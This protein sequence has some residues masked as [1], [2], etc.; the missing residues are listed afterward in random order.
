MV[1]AAQTNPPQGGGGDDTNDG[2]PADDPPTDGAERGS[3]GDGHLDA[4]PLISLFGGIRPMAAKLGV[5]VSTVQGWRERNAI[6]T[7]RLTSI[8]DAAAKNDITILPEH[9]VLQMGPPTPPDSAPG[10]RT[11]GAAKPRRTS[12]EQVARTPGNGWLAPGLAGAAV[13]I[14]VIALLATLLDGGSGPSSDSTGATQVAG[15][16]A[17]R[18]DD[19]A[20][21]A[22]SVAARVSVL[23]TLAE[24][25]AALD[26][27][28]TALAQRVDADVIG[29]VATLQSQLDDL[30]ALAREGGPDAD[31][32][33]ARMDDLAAGLDEMQGSLDDLAAIPAIPSAQADASGEI[34]ALTT[35][36]DGLA[37]ALAAVQGSTWAGDA[38]LAA[39]LA[40]RVDQ[41]E[42]VL[43]A[44]PAGI[45]SVGDGAIGATQMFATVFAT[46]RL[47]Q[48]LTDGGP[49][50]AVLAQ[51]AQGVGDDGELA[52]LVAAVDDAVGSDAVAT[53]PAL[54]RDF[55]AMAPGL[56]RA[57]SRGTTAVPE[58]ADWLAR[59]QA[60]LAQVVTVE[61]AEV[62][63]TPAEA[64]TGDT[65]AQAGALV[66]TGDLAAAAAAISGMADGTGAAAAWVTRAE[67]RVAVETALE[68]LEAAVFA[69]LADPQAADP[70]AADPQAADPQAVD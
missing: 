49:L 61:R 47:R 38:G 36:V 9:V 5:P 45:A 44:A 18:V 26:E 42:A 62:D 56:A 2:R 6:P 39:G 35:R 30:A 17:G 58:D 52:G 28:I 27:Q 4:H 32:L 70:Q 33:T 69:R 15:E 22:E 37:A 10:G 7:H 25:A 55:N 21:D 48:Q 31:G 67:R 8:K 43:D 60:R 20:A 65:I 46:L 11:G 41:L 54:V 14:A 40:R 1:S 51:A 19:L 66:A 53:R 3:G 34:A 57:V 13:V 16:V 50:G 68:A 23:E 59:A 63:G 12:T 64:G 29:Q 24:D